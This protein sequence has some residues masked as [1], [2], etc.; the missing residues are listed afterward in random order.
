M[1]L[2][3][4]LQKTVIVQI[5]GAQIRRDSVLHL[6]SPLLLYSFKISLYNLKLFDQV[7]LNIQDINSEKMYSYM[8]LV[9]V[10]IKASQT[11]NMLTM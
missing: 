7:I 8:G 4:Q 9:S 3:V 11:T 5:K 2:C 6:F 10:N 1:C